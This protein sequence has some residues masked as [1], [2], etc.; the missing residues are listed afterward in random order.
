MYLRVEE[1]HLRKRNNLASCNI[2]LRIVLRAGNNVAFQNA[3]RKVST[4]MSAFVVNGVVVAVHI[5]YQ[6]FFVK[7]LTFFIFPI[8]ISA[9]PATGTKFDSKNFL[10]PTSESGNVHT[11]FC[12]WVYLFFAHSEGVQLINMGE[13]L[14]C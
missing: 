12:G 5:G 10:P 4:C 2:K 7:E 8:G 9:F 11:A 14:L 6:N 1:T 3:L 13:V